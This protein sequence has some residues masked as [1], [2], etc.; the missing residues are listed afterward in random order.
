MEKPPH[1][2]RVDTIEGVLGV[3]WSKTTVKDN[4]V[5]ESTSSFSETTNFRTKSF[6]KHS[7]GRKY[8]GGILNSKVNKELFI[9]VDSSLR[10]SNFSTE[11]WKA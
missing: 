5:D 3:Y 11:E 4:I 2:D 6:W 8:V 10:G 7:E 1:H 9:F